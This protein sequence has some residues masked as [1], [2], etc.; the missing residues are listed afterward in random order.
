[1]LSS[2][3]LEAGIPGI[4]YLEGASRAKG[5]GDYNYVIF[6]EGAV[7]ITDK[8]YMPAGEGGQPSFTPTNRPSAPRG[9]RFMAPIATFGVEAPPERFLRN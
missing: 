1:M 5:K 2:A 3:L 9:N 7:T 4:K 6:D 8:L